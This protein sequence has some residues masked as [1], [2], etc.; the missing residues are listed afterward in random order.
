MI[1]GALQTLN[2]EAFEDVASTERSG[3]AP[4]ETLSQQLAP[5]REGSEFSASLDSGLS[6]TA[7]L[8]NLNNNG[9]LIGAGARR[10]SSNSHSNLQ[11]ISGSKSST[12]NLIG[13][14]SASMDLTELLIGAGDGNNFH[15]IYT[16]K[17]ITDPHRDHVV[18]VEEEEP[19]PEQHE[20][21]DAT[22]IAM[23]QFSQNLNDTSL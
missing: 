4:G 7:A 18:E 3:V 19:Q 14:S 16:T 17:C 22:I 8:T 12:N 9:N 5:I 2:E 13:G 6:V 21:K 10:S 20:N 11:G 15:R 23:S 1:C